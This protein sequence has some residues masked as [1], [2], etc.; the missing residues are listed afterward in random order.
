MLYGVQ[1]V[2]KSTWANVKGAIYLP[3]EEGL[4]NIDCE[5]FPLAKTFGEVKQRLRMLHDEPHNY[6]LLCIDTLDWLEPMIWQVVCEQNSKAKIEDIGYGKGYVYACDLWRELLA[7]LDRLRMARNMHIV[8]LAHAKVELFAD[9]RTNDY[10]RYTPRLHKL[11]AAVVQEWCDEVFFA[12][13]KV[14][15]SKSDGDRAAKGTGAGER[16]IYTE[17]RPF[18]LAKNRLSL[19]E[20]LEM[21]FQSYASHFMK[22]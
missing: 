7:C 16:V 8:L 10:Q 11:A 3:T 19:P 12:T 21:S 17:E 2:G 14:Y 6:R 4:N 1:G 20:E 9:P 22:G 13:F 5:S 15:A 18:A